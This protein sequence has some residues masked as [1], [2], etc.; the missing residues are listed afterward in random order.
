MIQLED[1]VVPAGKWLFDK[2]VTDSFEN[3]LERSIPQYSVMRKAVFDL[4]CEFRQPQTT[5]LDLGSS[6]GGAISS[7]IDKFGDSNSYHLTEISEPMLAV[8]QEIFGN[9]KLVTIQKCDLR[10]E[11]PNIQPMVILSILVLM[12]IPLECRPYLVKK[13]YDSLLP[14]GVF[15]CIEKVIGATP[16]I[17]RILTKLY[18]EKKRESG[19]SNESIERKRLSLQGV[20]VPV[21]GKWEEDLF[22]MAGFQKIECFWRWMN[23]SGWIA[24]K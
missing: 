20:L 8:L 11:F 4:A 14:G 9:N 19:Y 21:T 3:M 18:Y 16:D 7:L 1:N 6:R 17:D 12:F 5:F 2:E 13:I 15:I 22:Y 24:I 23:F 10:E